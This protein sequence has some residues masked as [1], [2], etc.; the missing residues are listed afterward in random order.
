MSRWK[1][2]FASVALCC[3][4]AACGSLEPADRYGTEVAEGQ[5]GLVR[6]LDSTQIPDFSVAW[7]DREGLARAAASSLDYLHAPSSKKYFPYGPVT[8]ERMARTI[9]RFVEVIEE[10]TTADEFRSLIVRDFEVWRSRGADD[11]G[12]VLFT[13]YCRPV[14]SGSATR[15]DRYRFPLYGLPDDLAKGADGAI[16]G[17]RTASG[18][19]VPYYTSAELR[20][21]GH[22]DGLEL[23]WLD[24]AFDAYIAQVQGSALIQLPDGSFIELGYAGKNGH[25][26][27]SIGELLIAEGNITKSELSLPRL[28]DYFRDNPQEVDRVLSLNPSFVFFQAL[29]GGPYGCLG[30]PVVASRSLATDKSVFPRGGLCFVETRLPADAESGVTLQRPARFFAFDQDRGGAIRSAGRC[31]IFL[32]TGAEATARAGNVLSLGRLYYLF[33]R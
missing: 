9:E 27:R 24:D 17:R 19:L 6:V 3:C 4:A 5:L 33:V 18:S 23:V 22:L 1:G 20:T 16:L 7:N 21:N 13:A 11:T 26:Y 12:D 28:R 15:D 32:G 10:A 25:P 2:L 29:P 31:D 30:Q 14:L 8:H